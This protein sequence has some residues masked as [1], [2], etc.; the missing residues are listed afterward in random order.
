MYCPCWKFE[1]YYNG[2]YKISSNDC[3]LTDLQNDVRHVR[4]P[5][6]S[7]RFSGKFGFSFFHGYVTV[8]RPFSYLSVSLNLLKATLLSDST[9][10]FR[11]SLAL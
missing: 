4:R 1:L 6:A 7:A 10:E 8:Y 2:E 9:G 5:T 11:H 3:I